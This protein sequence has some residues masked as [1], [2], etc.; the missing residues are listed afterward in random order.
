MRVDEKGEEGDRIEWERLRRKD[1]I[2]GGETVKGR[3]MEEGIAKRE[4]DSTGR[5]ED[6]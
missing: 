6:R 3:R 4:K 2:S 1:R 5:E